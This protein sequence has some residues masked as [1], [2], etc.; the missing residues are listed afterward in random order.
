LLVVQLRSNNLKRALSKKRIYDEIE[1]LELSIPYLSSFKNF[2]T[3][4]NIGIYKRIAYRK[5]KIELKG[6]VVIHS[7][8]GILT[9]QVAS[10]ISKKTGL[11]HINQV[12]GSDV[13][14][15]LP[16]LKEL[17]GVKNWEKNVH[18]IC[19]NSIDLESKINLLYPKNKTTVIYRGVDL[20]KVNFSSIESTN[21]IKFL[22]LGGLSIIKS[23]T[24]LNKHPIKSFN[25][26][27]EDL[28]GG[29]LLL[30][31]W[32]KWIND[33]KIKNA[34][35]HFGGPNVTND[36][37]ETI[38]N[39]KPEKYNI[40]IV[41]P[42]NHRDVLKNMEEA[43][44]IIVPSYAEGLPNIAMEAFAVGRPVIGSKVGGIPE[45]ITHKIDGYIFKNGSSVELIKA[46]DYFYNNQ[47]ELQLLGKNTRK[48]VVTHFDS[49]QF[50][51]N[52]NKLYFEES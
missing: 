8:G 20:E 49:T 52:Y 41:G 40:K 29:V 50:I 42:L 27:G 43:Q 51:K 38:I 48:K 34:E 14:Y 5:I 35:L 32:Q 6:N 13:N 47:D 33:Y 26:L 31:S 3:A 1:V 37:I 44:V 19:C 45:L 16:E 11:K 2:F 17:Y 22:F 21:T 46:I 7:V 4:F 39:D 9:G 15:I 30:K 10:Y 23:K 24:I 28:K 12:I 25:T 36:K 18:T